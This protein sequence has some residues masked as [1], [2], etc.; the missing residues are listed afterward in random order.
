[1]KALQETVRYKQR[2]KILRIKQ[3]KD[4]ANKL[5]KT[6]TAYEKWM[7]TKQKLDEEIHYMLSRIESNKKTF[8]H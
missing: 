4:D 3:F 7:I 6:I 2:V 1:M 5:A 8:S